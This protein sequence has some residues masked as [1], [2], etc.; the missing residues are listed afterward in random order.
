M[1]KFRGKLCGL[2]A[3][4]CAHS[5]YAKFWFGAI[6][7]ENTLR[8][9]IVLA[10]AK[11]AG[12]TDWITRAGQAVFFVY[13]RNA[14]YTFKTFFAAT[15]IIVGITFGRGYIVRNAHT[16]KAVIIFIQAVTVKIT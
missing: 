13:T 5:V 9:E 1:E 4:A 8:I 10:H 3:C 14:A 12:A 11:A 2:Q 15:A 16:F 6:T 7:V